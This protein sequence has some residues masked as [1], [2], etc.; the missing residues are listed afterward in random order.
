MLWAV[1][2]RLDCLYQ[3]VHWSYSQPSTLFYGEFVLE[4]KN[5]V[6]QADCL[7]P[8]LFSLALQ[9]VLEDVQEKCETV[10]VHAYL[11]DIHLVGLPHD[12]EK[13]QQRIVQTAMEISLQFN[14]SKSIV[15]APNE[16]DENPFLIDVR[17]D[18]LTV[19]GTPVGSAEFIY[20][21]LSEK[22]SSH[23]ELF[24]AI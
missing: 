18:G 20:S 13:A 21:S 8:F 19:L 16:V 11:D 24:E 12:V 15:F 22:L 5:G 6:R 7:G 10:H 17:H 4:S 2:S 14:A 1:R 9:S 3:F 23:D